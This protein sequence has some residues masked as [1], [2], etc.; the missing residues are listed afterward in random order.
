M[1]ARKVTLALVLNESF[2]GFWTR[3]GALLVLPGAYVNIAL[4]RSLKIE[5]HIEI[6]STLARFV[7]S[8]I[9]HSG[10]T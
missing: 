3:S 9:L 5:K 10:G 8:S 4:L 2:R 1:P 7:D 6:R